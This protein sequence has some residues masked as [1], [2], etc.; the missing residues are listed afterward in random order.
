MYMLAFGF[1]ALGFGA[2]RHL[3]GAENEQV[4]RRPDRAFWTRPG[5]KTI[6]TGIKK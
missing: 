5:K 3:S 4:S 2:A 6:T 1:L